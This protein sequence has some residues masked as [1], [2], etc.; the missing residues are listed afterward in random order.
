M[1]S[2]GWD[3]R[4]RP[5]GEFSSRPFLQREGGRTRIR[6]SLSRENI[7][8]GHGGSAFLL[9]PFLRGHSSG[10]EGNRSA[11]RL[12]Y[13]GRRGSWPRRPRTSR[14][15]HAYGLR[16]PRS[17]EQGGCAGEQRPGRSRY[18][19]VP[20]P[21]AIR[22][23]AGSSPPGERPVRYG[24]RPGRVVGR[25]LRL[26]GPR[27]GGGRVDL[28]WRL[29]AKPALLETA[30][31]R[32]R[33]VPRPTSGPRPRFTP[34]SARTRRARPASHQSVRLPGLRPRTYRSGLMVQ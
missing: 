24:S 14:T 8:H 15:Q 30:L 21:V 19:F 4:R 13:P 11:T 20:K 3:E 34:R 25:F 16:R 22:K 33:Y 31:R 6:F 29:G 7:F 32:S 10:G 17:A 26:H 1:S 23:A 12:G 9:T 27:F 18:S 28:G 2:A 5:N